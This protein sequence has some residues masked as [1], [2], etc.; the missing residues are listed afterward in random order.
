[1]LTKNTAIS[2]RKN[3]NPPQKW[4]P[5]AYRFGEILG[6]NKIKYA[7]FG[8]GSLAAHQI[9]TRPTI[10]IDFVV[11]DYPKAIKLI[12]DQPNLSSKNLKKDNDGIPVADFHFNSGVSVQIW[13]RNLYS[14]PMNSL[15]WQKASIRTI[16]G[17]G[18]LW[19]ISVEDII[20]SKVGRYSQQRYQNKNE[21]NKNILD[22]LL[23]II[24][25]K[26]PDYRYIIERLKEGAR[27]ESSSSSALHSLDWFF[28]REIEPYNEK[29]GKIDYEKVSQFVS[30]IVMSIRSREVEYYLLNSLRKLKNIKK[31]Q[32]RFMLNDKSLIT[33]LQRWKF[34]EINNNQ[35]T[36]TSKEIQ[37][38]LDTLPKNNISD[39]YKQILY[40][41][42]VSLKE[43]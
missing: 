35:A 5:E 10:D 34:I 31:F 24:A 14:L 17:Y 1:M 8:A 38:Y 12:E 20:V 4:L 28:I 30:K 7:I 22:I 37:I 9:I 43:I 3:E 18:N 41:G 27:K 25:L 40:S 39:Y 32:Q 13:N 2:Q 19:T 36:L 16:P 26:R 15:S 33:L 29:I 42:K 11:D 21:A 6:T 23:T